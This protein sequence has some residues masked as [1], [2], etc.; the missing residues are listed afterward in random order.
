MSNNNY[1]RV[2][3]RQAN[4]T[5]QGLKGKG[6]D[7]LCRLIDEAD[8]VIAVYRDSSQSHGVGTHII[9]GQRLLKTVVAE[10]ES[11][12][13]RVRYIPCRSLEEAINLQ[14]SIGEPDALH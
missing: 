7:A 9:K 12:P 5:G 13:A 10:Q 8:V 1:L 11:K 3:I 4:A 14:Q 6:L 2:I